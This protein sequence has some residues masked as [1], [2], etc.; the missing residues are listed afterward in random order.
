MNWKTVVIDVTT[1]IVI[2]LL[3]FGFFTVIE[4]QA[5]QIGGFTSP[6]DLQAQILSNPEFAEDYA[7]NLKTFT[8]TFSIGTIIAVLLTL[9][10]FS[11]SRNYIYT[12]KHPFKF[13]W[14][15]VGF[16][17]LLF[18]ITIPYLLILFF[19]FLWLLNLIPGQATQILTLLLLLPLILVSILAAKSFTKNNKVWA[20]IGHAFSNIKTV[21]P[22]KI[23]VVY[24]ITLIIPII[25][26]HARLAQITA[27]ILFILFIN[28]TRETLK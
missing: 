17:L 18:L 25:L 15:W 22:A 6:E 11:V 4:N 5:Y 23:V 28:W 2:A 21:K 12:K 1:V 16:E 13:Q 7:T 27:I 9:L 19:L 20:S 10:F 24:L 26:P 3:W 8:L 14:K